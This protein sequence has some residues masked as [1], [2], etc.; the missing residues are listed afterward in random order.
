MNFSSI[1]IV[2]AGGFLGSIARYVT[3]RS[4][5]QKL[6]AVFPYGTIT[7]NIAG[8]FILGVLVGMMG[9]QSLG[10]DNWKLFLGTGFCGGFTTFSAFALEN[11]S[12]LQGRLAS[13][14]IT[15]TLISLILGF[16]AVIAG[17]ALGRIFG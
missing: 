6:N 1:L 5:D 11:V 10:S 16:L 15:Y 8:S 9:K 2:G 17:A 7:V 3:V 14:S 12:L 13:T 4:I